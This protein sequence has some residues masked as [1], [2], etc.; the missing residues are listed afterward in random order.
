MIVAHWYYRLSIYRSYI[1]FDSV[2]SITIIK[3]WSHLHWRTIPNTSPSRSSY[4]VSFTS[5][6]IKND[7]YI[8]R[9]KCIRY[10]GFVF[11]MIYWVCY[12]HPSCLWVLFSDMWQAMNY[13]QQIGATNI[14]TEAASQPGIPLKWLQVKAAQYYMALYTAWQRYPSQTH[15]KLR[16]CNILLVHK[17]CFCCPIVLKYC[18][19]HGNMAVQ[20]FKMIG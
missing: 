10:G 3:F 7:C 5:H 16:C 15:L 13:V 19:E 17:S 8:L 14:T 18:T 11:L 9:S 4:G 2:H 12:Q 20:N 1:W 6:T